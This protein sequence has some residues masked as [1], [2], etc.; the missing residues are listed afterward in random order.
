MLWATLL[1]MQQVKESLS[2]QHQHLQAK[3][4]V[5]KYSLLGKDREILCCLSQ[6]AAEPFAWISKLVQIWTWHRTIGL[7]FTHHFINQ[8]HCSD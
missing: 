2:W 3:S 6:R 5:A 4:M 1:A 7:C 8:S